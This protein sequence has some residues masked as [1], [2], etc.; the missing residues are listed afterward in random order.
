MNFGDT[1]NTDEL[2]TKDEAKKQLASILAI[3]MWQHWK[4]AR[5]IPS[6]AQNTA[7]A[8]A[9]ILEVAEVYGIKAEVLTDYHV[10]IGA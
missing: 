8:H 3:D 4:A 10:I 1:R 5:D 9:N 2:M 6:L 7:L